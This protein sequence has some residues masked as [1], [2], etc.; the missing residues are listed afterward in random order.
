MRKLILTLVAFA[1]L[2]PPAFALSPTKALIHKRAT[3]CAWAASLGFR[4]HKEFS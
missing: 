3:F 4:C 1:L 2:A